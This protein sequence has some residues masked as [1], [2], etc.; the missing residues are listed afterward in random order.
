MSK[1]LSG[2]PQYYQE[3]F[4]DPKNAD[5]IYS[6]DVY[7]M[8]SDDG[9][10]T[11]R[12]AGE[13]YKHVDN[14]A[15]WIDPENTDHLLNGNDGGVYES[16]DRAGS[17][18][19]KANLPI[20]Q[21]YRVAVDDAAPIYNVYGG[22]Q[23]NFSLGGPSRTAN[24]QGIANSDWFVTQGGDGFVSRVDPKDPN[25]VYAESQHGGLVRFDKKTGERVD[26]Q[27]QPGKGDAPLRFNWDS[28]L[29]ISPHAPAR[30]YFAAQRLFRSDDRGSSWRAV[31]PDLTRQIDRNKLKVMGR[32]WS[33]DAVAKNTSTSFYGNIVSLSESPKAEGLLYVG[34]DDGLVQVSEDAG[35]SWRKLEHFPGV[36]ELTYVSDLK[37]SRHDASTV[38]AAF[39]NHKLADFKP[40]LLRSAD[41]GKT[42]VSIAGDLPARGSV[43]CVAEDAERPEL[44][45]AGTEFGVYF[46]LDAGKRW[47]QMKGGLPTIA[48]RDIA[49]Q[50]RETDL[51]LAS[52][53]R[54]FFILDDYSP[55]RRA[56]AALLEQEAA[57]FPV[58]KA[59]IN[60]PALPLGLR[61]KSFQG[62]AYFTAPNPPAGAVFSYYLKDELKTKQQTRQEQEKKT[63]EKGGDVFYPSWDELR[64]EA[65]EEEPALLLIVTD[66]AGNVVR[67]LSGPAKAGFQRVAWDLR[68]PPADPTSL[69]PRSDDNPFDDPPIG[70][71]VAP[72]S[73]KVQLAKR[74]DGQVTALGE[75]QTFVAEPVGVASLPAAERAAILEFQQQTARLQR[76]VLG[77]HEAA[78][79][80]NKR[81]DHLKKALEDTPGA[82]PK[83]ASEARAIEARLKDLQ[84]A[85]DGDAVLR[86]HNEPTLPG[87][88]ERVQ[89]IVYGH[90]QATTG[91]T[92]THRQAYAVAAEE[93]APQ[94][95]RLRALVD[96][97]LKALE[98]RAETAGAP[99]TPGRVPRWKR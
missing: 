40:Y 48:I 20:T 96:V 76:A 89:G 64:A 12:H 30:L 46:S 15:L 55:L 41:R 8:V 10:G 49:I 42:W 80:T 82:D 2:G 51:V 81:I 90:W 17:W 57:L 68:Y 32:V 5:R 58:K 61:D 72:G 16:W 34:T 6:M 79:E 88:V 97:E 22:T 78:Q 63:A 39:D 44:L 19:F 85:L 74:V 62:A 66:A 93:F 37:A 4:V 9:G 92:A 1:Y 50:E 36:P 77:A 75:T 24:G 86:R 47:V 94:L 26:I 14:H 38:Y 54:G 53:G 73:Y 3:I 95:E 45:F 27:P 25:I 33:V 52:F 56:S 43:Y 91:P 59:A 13:R 31:S 67:R 84:V 83:L 28:P 71:L 69:E 7:L 70:P 98:E 99:W 18:A 21:F 11:F 87:I 29:I 65:R 23:D 35:G 60:V